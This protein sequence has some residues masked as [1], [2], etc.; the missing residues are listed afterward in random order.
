MMSVRKEGSMAIKAKKL[1]AK[2]RRKGE[3]RRCPAARAAGR[4]RADEPG[5]TTTANPYRDM[6]RE[7]TTALWL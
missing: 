7:Y 4:R 3:R 6:Q 5:T 2:R 1:G